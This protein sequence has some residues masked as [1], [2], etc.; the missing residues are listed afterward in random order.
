MPPLS[1]LASC[2]PTKC[3]LYLDRSFKAVIREPATFKLL[4]SKYQI[5][6][7]YFLALVV[8]KKNLSNSEALSDIS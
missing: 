1:H 5:L 4:H 6:Y 2:I 3:N 7:P 8:Y